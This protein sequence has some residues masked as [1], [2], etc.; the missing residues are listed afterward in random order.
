[1][2]NSL[3]PV[4]LPAHVDIRAGFP[5]VTEQ[6]YNSCVAESLAAAYSYAA[7]LQVGRTAHQLPSRLFLY[8]Q[9]RLADGMERRDEGAFIG[10]GAQSLV[11]SGV[12]E[13]KYHTYSVGPLLRP[14]RAA[15]ADA[16]DH[17][18]ISVKMVDQNLTAIKDLLARNF[19]VVIG[20]LVYPSIQSALVE[21]TGDVPLPSAAEMRSPPL[22]G[23]AVVLVGYDEPTQKFFFRNSWGTQWGTQGHGTFPY[24]YILD[25][26]L[27]QDFWVI[28][29]VND[30]ATPLPPIPDP[31]PTPVPV[32]PS[33][34]PPVPDPTPPWP[35]PPTPWPDPPIPD[36]WPVITQCCRDCPPDYCCCARTRQA[37][38]ITTATK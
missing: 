8:Y 22:G 13:E 37:G 28:L 12:C 16:P 32:P 6:Q 34:I 20:F 36:P 38:I 26:F 24:A 1:M 25:G 5:P 21:R 14:S 4:A 3:S 33:P 7:I 31:T 17:V 10:S 19:P 2:E 15:Y 35:D 9:A 23:H 30:S 11:A 29:S 18:A 27:S